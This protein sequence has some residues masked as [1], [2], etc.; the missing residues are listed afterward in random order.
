MGI[1]R[2]AKFSG[3]SSPLYYGKF[4]WVNF[5]LQKANFRNSFIDIH[6]VQSKLAIVYTRD[7]RNRDLCQVVQY[8]GYMDAYVSGMQTSIASEVVWLAQD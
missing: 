5:F 4:S 3:K 6:Q 2:R 1:F 7:A 8:C